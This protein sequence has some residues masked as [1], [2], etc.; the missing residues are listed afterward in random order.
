MD[1]LE[2]CLDEVES[3]KRSNPARVKELDRS[4]AKA[5]ELISGLYGFEASQKP[6]LEA[7]VVELKRERRALTD[8]K[9]YRRFTSL[10]P[11]TWRDKKTGYPQVVLFDLDSPVF[12][13]KVNHVWRYRWDFGAGV[14]SGTSVAK[15]NLP[16]PLSDC[17]KDVI[18]TLR[19]QAKRRRRTVTLSCEYAGII[20]ASVKAKIEE[21][22][23][24]F[25]RVFIMAQGTN[26][27]LKTS[28]SRVINV[29]DPLIVGW[30]GK[31]L[32][33]VDKFDLTSVERLIA[34]EFTE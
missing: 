12:S 11:L 8:R 3:R 19:K 4:I 22:K 31:D 29:G 7:G 20:P 9:G 6:V 18:S 2:K 24:A 30:D 17:Y 33:L 26:W 13:F 16:G 14:T 28:A 25:E 1:V 23:K 10:A 21:A 5:D 34:S 27:S 15:S 32:W